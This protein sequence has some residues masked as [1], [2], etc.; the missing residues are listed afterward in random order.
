MRLEEKK[1]TL[2]RTESERQNGFLILSQKGAS[3]PHKKIKGHSTIST[4][5]MIP[6]EVAKGEPSNAETR[7]EKHTPRKTFRARQL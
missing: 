7:Y 1:T 4:K 3:N 5:M 2:G 6:A